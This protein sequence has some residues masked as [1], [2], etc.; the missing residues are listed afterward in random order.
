MEP[1][2]CAICNNRFFGSGGLIY[3]KETD[4]DIVFNERLKQPGFVGH[5]SNAFWF[6]EK[7]TI[8][9]KKYSYLTKT[10]TFEILKNLEENTKNNLK[11]K[12][13]D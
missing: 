5:P 3:F 2:I 4:E 6:C 12:K 1:P 11:N 10:E 9:A 7:H 8:S 13:N